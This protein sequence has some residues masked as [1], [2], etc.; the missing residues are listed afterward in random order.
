MNREIEVNALVRFGNRVGI[1]TRVWDKPAANPYVTVK[2][3]DGK[4][5]VRFAAE[6][7]VI[8]GAEHV[9]PF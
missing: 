2:T 4:T 9:P 7:T 3:L 8:M 1:I 6:C 5:F